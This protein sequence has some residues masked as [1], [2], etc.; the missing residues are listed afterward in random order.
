LAL[1]VLASFPTQAVSKEMAK[2]RPNMVIEGTAKAPKVITEEPGWIN[3][4]RGSISGSRLRWL[5]VS[6]SKKCIQLNKSSGV[7]IEDAE[8][9][10]TK[11]LDSKQIPTAIWFN[12]GS[13]AT[14]RNVWVHG[15]DSKPCAGCYRQGDGLVGDYSW[16]GL[17]LDNVRLTDNRDACADLKSRNV[18]FTTLILERCSRPARIW[19]DTWRGDELRIADA[20]SA[21]VYMSS[22]VSPTTG[23]P[24]NAGLVV[25]RFRYTNRVTTAPAF[26]FSGANASVEVLEG[27]FFDVLPQTPAFRF[28]DGA[29]MSNVTRK[30]PASCLPDAQG[31]LVNT[32]AGPAA[33]SAAAIVVD[34][35]LVDGKGRTTGD[36]TLGGS[37]AKRL[38][39]PIG[40]VLRSLG[41]TRY[42]VVR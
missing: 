22:Q 19:W 10:Q 41:G 5:K 14:L 35:P 12:T 18:T 11:A 25:K 34:P 42:E 9:T 15:F 7:L 36:F 37:T 16:I 20:T 33:A 28:A 17:H 1:I 26:M 31:Y 40:T 3:D 13:N 29:K 24:K 32:P 23:L 2:P 4:N 21:A 27:C 8:F 6:C 30:L 39:L 38:A